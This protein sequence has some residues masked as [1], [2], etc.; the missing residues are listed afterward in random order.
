MMH[1]SFF[2]LLLSVSS[3][4]AF[5]P[6]VGHSS[7]LVTTS[8]KPAASASLVVLSAKPGEEQPEEEEKKGG[9]FA[10]ISNF[11]TELDNF[12]D[13]A[14]ARRLGAGASF[15]GKRKS[16]FYGEDDK[17]KK[18]TDGYDPTGMCYCCVNV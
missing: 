2:A 14:S 13:D 15:Y 1:K 16:S 7:R 17:M 18:T 4:A 6:A 3:V 9:L 11:F 10:G 8:C 5:A 12:M